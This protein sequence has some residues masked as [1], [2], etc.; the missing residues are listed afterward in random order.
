MGVAL[1]PA[2]QQ[3]VEQNID[4]A[5]YI[6]WRCYRK[7]YDPSWDKQDLTAAAMVG[8]CIAA[9]R[10]DPGSGHAFSTYAY[11]TIR[12]AV[13]HFFRDNRPG[14]LR[15]PRTVAKIPPVLSLDRPVV[16]SDGETKQA[17]LVD[18]LADL[19][20]TAAVASIQASI[21][22]LPR[23]ERQA[24][25]LATQGLT[26][27]E[28]GRGL[29]C[30]QVHVFR[31]LRSAREKLGIRGGNRF[32]PPRLRPRD[33]RLPSDTTPPANGEVRV[34]NVRDL[35]PDEQD[36][37]R[38]ERPTRADLL[39]A[40][41]AGMTIEDVAERYGRRSDHVIIMCNRLGI[42]L[43]TRRQKVAAE[44]SKAE[45]E[46]VANPTAQDAIIRLDTDLPDPDPAGVNKV[47]EPPFLTDAPTPTK[48]T[49][50]TWEFKVSGPMPL[51]QLWS[52]IG[53]LEK[54]LDVGE[55]PHVSLSIG[56]VER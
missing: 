28:I 37:Y 29:G 33:V 35:P 53:A 15:I 50:L 14:G 24:M 5:R 43:P 46:T 34:Y 31:L 1:T 55:A 36:K 11:P 44:K 32:M 2:Q 47:M 17:Y 4:L 27:V 23:K 6:A 10:F 48:R 19:S 7:N 18:L 25:L 21:A 12:G 8:L 40:K 49:D 22:S 3:L 16:G 9:A 41:E 13:L 45:V 54:S 39:E 52:I 20:D 56:R 51:S 30:S 38:P 26:Q 42:D